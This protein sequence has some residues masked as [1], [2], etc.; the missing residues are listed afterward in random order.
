MA[1]S[2]K[3]PNCE[4]KADSINKLIE[5]LGLS[6]G[7]YKMII[8]KLGRNPNFTELVMFSAMWSE[9]CSYKNSILLLKN[10]YAQSDRL[11]AKPGSEN[12]GV[13]KLNKEYAV[14]FKIESH[15]HPSAIEPYQGAATGMGGIMRDIFTMGARPIASLNSLRFGELTL[16]CNQFLFEQVVKGIGDYGNSLG[17]PCIGGEIFFH[18]SFTKN[19]LVNAMSIGI[20]K[21]KD[22]A[23]SH[24]KGVGNLVVYAGAKT[25]RDG[26]HGA[27][28]ASK[29]LSK[30]ASEER[31]AIQVGDPFMEKLLM[32]ASLECIQ[33]KLLIA[34]QDM[35]AAGLLSSS[36]EMAASGSVGM[37]L[38]MEK[39]PSREKNMKPFELMLS[40]SQE[41][42]LLVLENKNLNKVQEIYQKWELTAIPIG[43]ITQKETLQIFMGEEIYAEIPPK[44]LTKEAPR[45]QRDIQEPLK[46]HLEKDSFPCLLSHELINDKNY[47]KFEE[48]LADFLSSP[49]LASKKYIYEQYDTD[50]GGGR[51]LGPGQNA[52]LVLIENTSLGIVASVDCRSDYVFID[53]YL[54]TQ[55]SVAEAYRNIISTG[56]KPIGITNCLNFAN[57]YNSENFYYFKHAVEGMSDAAQAFEVP[58]TGGNVSLYNE[59]VDGPVLPTP[60]IGMI[61]LHESPQQALSILVKPQQKIYLLG[62]FR[63]N[64][65]S[66]Y[67]Q[68]YQ[69]K[70]QG[71]NLPSLNLSIEKELGNL[72]LKLFDNDLL[73]ASIDISIGGLLYALL[74]IIFHSREAYNKK[75][76]FS[77]QANA[78][79]FFLEKYKKHDYWLWGESAHSYLVVIKKDKEEEIFKLISE[80]KATRIEALFLGEVTTESEIC[81][82]P[83]FTFSLEKAYQAW[84]SLGNFIL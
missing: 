6:K 48:F 43:E 61:G 59:S 28:F 81:L 83:M 51:I 64:L 34:I 72:F 73:E 69:T 84:N 42:M 76:G 50:I 35:G 23:S 14:V 75:L 47:I 19:P 67:Y 18:N 78:I 27:S 41:R 4:L 56:A 40:E 3:T 29:D 20:V 30:T 60:T 45:Y 31:S 11:L 25:G 15:N 12:A 33:K 2:S 63:P 13:L 17:I 70:K 10:L 80:E 74:K 37:K 7:E 65:Q 82:Q 66:S 54:G 55:H 58:I 57:P 16:P 38:H 1:E 71:I 24:A 26:I 5:K 22:I 46:T 49:N 21:I 36:S 8:D 39:V 77:F 53:P 32:E 68:Y 79:K 62:K 52:G 9:H 44:L